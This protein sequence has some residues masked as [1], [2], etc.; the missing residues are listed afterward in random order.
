M[1]D[2]ET[3][4][5]PPSTDPWEEIE[6]RWDEVIFRAT[7]G[8]P[9]RTMGDFA[10]AIRQSHG[11]MT[12]VAELIGTYWLTAREVIDR[13]PCLRQVFDA[14]KQIMIDIAE[15]VVEGNIRVSRALAM[16]AAQ[17]GAN[18]LV[19]SSDSR[20]ILSRL[21][22]DRGY[23]EQVSVDV[24]AEKPIPIAVIQPGELEGLMPKD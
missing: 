6:R 2:P 13:N 21:A 8:R 19:D 3:V 22:R 24:T 20:W 7:K 15:S 10:T 11:I 1:A 5:A 18:V 16:S 17:N 12:T 4:P 14:E 9:N 23:G